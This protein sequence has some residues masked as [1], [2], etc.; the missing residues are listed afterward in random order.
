MASLIE[1]E[2]SDFINFATN[3]FVTA[4]ISSHNISPISHEDIRTFISTLSSDINTLYLSTS[5]IIIDY[6][7]LFNQVSNSLSGYA[8]LSGANFFGDIYATNLSGTNTGDQDLTSYALLSSV[9]AL[10]TQ[11]KSFVITNPTVSAEYAIW[12]APF[13]LTI[14]GLHGII[15]QGSALS[16]MLLEYDGNKQN[17]VKINSTD[18]VLLTSNVSLS[19]FSNPIIDSGDYIGW[20]N[21]GISGDVLNATISF[22]YIRN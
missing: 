17:P 15:N 21:T 12:R 3:S 20:T 7:N 2:V 9:A 13:A 1:V 19:S 5:A 6:T 18:T 8:P 16:G 11:T 4:A 14:T 22:E 10:Q